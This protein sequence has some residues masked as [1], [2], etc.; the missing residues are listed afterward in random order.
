MG[1][2]GGGGW[3]RRIWGEGGARACVSALKETQPC[4]SEGVSNTTHFWGLNP[5]CVGGFV[6]STC[7]RV[8]CLYLRVHMFIFV[9]GSEECFCVCL[10]AY[11]CACVHMKVFT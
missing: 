11:V 10:C 9:C 5:G 2:V 4:E 1:G 3:R 7:T 6:Y 8:R